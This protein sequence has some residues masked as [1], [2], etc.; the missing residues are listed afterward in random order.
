MRREIKFLPVNFTNAEKLEWSLI[1]IIYTQYLK[2][3]I[4][5]TK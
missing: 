1:F 2:K 4:F 3:T 5:N